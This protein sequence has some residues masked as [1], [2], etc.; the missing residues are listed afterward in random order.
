MTDNLENPERG[1]PG[2]DR[3]A[4][5]GEGRAAFT[6]GDIAKALLWFKRA[7][8][9]AETAESRGLLFKTLRDPRAAQHAGPF[10]QDLARALFEPWGDPHELLATSL[11][12]LRQDAV[13]L[14]CIA[15]AANAGTDM[16]ATRAVFAAGDLATL[17]ANPLLCALLE[18]GATRLHR[19]RA[20]VHGHAGGAA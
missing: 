2:K 3:Q 14:Q 16:A 18:F 17:A 20:A 1:L 10:R 7:N 11:S 6:R 13:L 12:V 19:G 15:R 4:C 8:D 5:I 9:A